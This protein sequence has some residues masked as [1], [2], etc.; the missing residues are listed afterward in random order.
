MKKNSSLNK[1]NVNSQQESI[2][3]N[4]IRHGCHSMKEK[5]VDNINHIGTWVQRSQRI[6]KVYKKNLIKDFLYSSF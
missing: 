5:I 1:K 6:K 2:L 3:K 4:K